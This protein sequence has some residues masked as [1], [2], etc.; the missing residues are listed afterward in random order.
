VSP[1]FHQLNKYGGAPRNCPVCGSTEETRDHIIR[2]PAPSRAEW[3]R[4]FWEAIDQFHT[5][6]RTA[7]LL[8]HVLRSA[9]GDWFQ[10]ESVI[11]VSPILYPMD[12]RKLI[13]EQNAIGWKQLFSGR[14]SIEWSQLQQRYY[15]KHRKK[16]EYQRRD[17]SQWQVKL[18]GV[19]WDQ[20]RHVWRM[21]N[22]A[23]HGHDK[24]TRASAERAATD[25]DLR[26]VYDQR[27]HLEPQVTSLLHQDEHEHRSRSR[28]TNKNWLAVNLPIIRRSVRRVKKR[29]ARGMQS[30]RSYFTSVPSGDE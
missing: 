4:T 27:Q 16:V 2:C 11:D 26:E 10:E 19:M 24:A 14:F 21:R 28:A 23:V 3:R 22:E 12:V 13:L 25:R 7:P 20:W 9:L 6:Y 29:S 8:I 17:G 5:E 1:D 30:L 18:I 15:S